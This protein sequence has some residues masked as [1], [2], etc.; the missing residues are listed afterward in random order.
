[1]L[2]SL[3]GQMIFTPHGSYPAVSV[4]VGTANWRGLCLCVA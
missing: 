4:L 2:V 3:L 1:M